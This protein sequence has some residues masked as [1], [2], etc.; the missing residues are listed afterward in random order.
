MYL[1]WIFKYILFRN[2]VCKELFVIDYSIESHIMLYHYVDSCIGDKM[3]S[4]SIFIIRKRY[5][6]IIYSK[7]Y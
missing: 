5:N 2:L 6:T 3:Y 4:K 7:N 1:E